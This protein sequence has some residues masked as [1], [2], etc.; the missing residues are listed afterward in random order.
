MNLDLNIEINK[1]FE[2]LKD[3]YK[4]IDF[5]SALYKKDDSWNRI[6]TI[7]RFSNKSESEINKHYEDLNLNRFK[8][9]NFKIEY[10]IFEVSKWEDT[11]IELYDELNEDLEIY[12][13]D[14]FHYKENQYEE[15][16]STFLDEFKAIHN[17]PS[18]RFFYTEEEVKKHNHIN[19]Y[20]SL[21]N[22]NEHHNKFNKILNEEILGLGEDNIYD[23]LNRTLQLD[24]YSSITGLFISILFPIYIN[25]KDLVYS[26]DVLSGNVY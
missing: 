5:R 10:K 25:I 6:L 7:I 15:Y 12:D 20:Y 26:Q 9:E 22:I 23:V 8:T 21:P 1:L 24:G 3:S 16:E 2:L 11:I 19:F 17:T 18:R 14:E 13:I 4:N